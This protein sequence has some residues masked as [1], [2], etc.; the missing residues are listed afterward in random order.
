MVT[1]AAKIDSYSSSSTGIQ[2]TFQRKHAK[3]KSID[4][5]KTFEYKDE[6][7]EDLRGY[8][9]LDALAAGADSSN[10]AVKNGI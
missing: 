2:K 3:N 1:Y 7:S 9:A 10:N 8:Q 4:I 6:Q 5:N